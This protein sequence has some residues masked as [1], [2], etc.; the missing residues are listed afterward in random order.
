MS[1]RQSW[2]LMGASAALFV[3]AVMSAGCATAVKDLKIVENA[4]AETVT[5][6]YR[7]LNSFDTTKVQ[8]IRARALTGDIGGSFTELDAYVDLRT[9]VFTALD[10][11]E[12]LLNTTD[13]LID[14]VAAG[15]EKPSALVGQIP[16]LIQAALDVK[17]AL[18]ALGVKL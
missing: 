7:A 18:T 9:K 1:K 5:L 6:G 11:A 17:D 16:K 13:K 10:T 15:V 2:A 12:S 4:T 8:L 14:A 3:L